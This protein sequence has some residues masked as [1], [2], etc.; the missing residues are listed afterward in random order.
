MARILKHDA[1]RL[2]GNVPAEYVF[3]CRDGNTFRN[4]RELTEAL[5]T[6]TEETFVFHANEEK[7]D[8]SNW[9]G[10]VIRDEKLARD[11]RKALNQTQA[12][13]KVMQRITFL[14]GKLA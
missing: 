13:K 12:A 14:E 7:N 11:L 5:T 1:E 4:L 9:V 8:F 2:L 10:D 3:Q 6:M